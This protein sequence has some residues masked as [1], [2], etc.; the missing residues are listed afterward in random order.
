[1]FQRERK[2][3][4]KSG[5]LVKRN[6]GRFRASAKKIIFKGLGGL[7]GHLLATKKGR[8]IINLDLD[9]SPR[10]NVKNVKEKNRIVGFKHKQNC[11]V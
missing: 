10:V 1:M 8:R 5:P 3:R 7:G 9:S 11:Y 6:E 4:V 2:R